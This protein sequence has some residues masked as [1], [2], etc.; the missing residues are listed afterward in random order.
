VEKFRQLGLSEEIIEALQAK[1]FEEPTP[2]QEQTIPLLLSDER[3]VIGQAQTGTGKTAAFGLPIIETLIPK[4]PQVQAL[5][6]TPTRELTLQVA[7]ELNSLKGKKALKIVPIY[8]GQSFDK[9]RAQLNKQVDV[10]VGTPGRIIDHIK[11]KT[12]KLQDLKFLILDEADEMLSVGFKEEIERILSETNDDKKT[13][14]FSATMPDS[15]L[16]IAK[17]YMKEYVTVRT[18]AKDL[19]QDLTAQI[20][21]EVRESDK[22]EALCRIIDL[23]LEFYGLIFCRTKRDVDQVAERLVHRGY[24]VE[25][26]HGDLS[27][28][29]RERVLGKFRKKSVTILVVT[30]VASRGLDIN[31]LSHVINF[32]LP[33]DS[34]SYIHRIGRTG[35]AGKSGTA[36]TF[37]TPSEYRKLMRMQK[38]AKADIKK[39]QLPTAKSVIE[40]KKERLKVQIGDGIT[41][42]IADQYK[43]FAKSL[44]ASHDPEEAVASILK[45]AFESLFN[46]KQYGSFQDV[47]VDKAG[48]TRLFV[49]KGRADDMT[50]RKLVAYIEKQSNVYG[51]K[52]Q[53]V[54]I[55]D[56]F[57]FISV[58]FKDAEKILNAFRTSKSQGR[59]LVT[60][61]KK[62]G[63]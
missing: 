59:S 18:K 41:E 56:N 33:Q 27:Q 25:A 40:S 10:V 52:I 51:R 45:I 16:N 4:Q 5:V 42:G 7:A 14:L 39:G 6:L 46:S 13:L 26:L 22:L 2:I 11:R 24:D 35:R 21:F 58:E 43:E 23:E 17:N 44:V 57:S 12:L 19:R 1:G 63:E 53:D 9:Q 36:I 55:L 50:P 29:Q 49:A 60:M 30:D 38:M 37:I 31:D 61:A 15:I 32:A 34:E 54:Q 28:H 48:Q 8:G 20:Y 62:K 3:D 47:S